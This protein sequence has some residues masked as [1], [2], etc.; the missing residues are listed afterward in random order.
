MAE[1]AN[2][3]K[4]FSS[5]PP[6]FQFY[7]NDWLASQTVSLMTPEQEGA[8][9]RLLAH[10]WSDPTCSLPDDDDRLAVLSRLG[11]KWPAARLA[12]AKQMLFH[13]PRDSGRIYNVRLYR[14]R[15]QLEALSLKRKKAGRKGGN[16]KA[17]RTDDQSW[18]EPSNCQASDKQLG[19]SSSSSPL[20]NRSSDAYGSLF[21]NE[22]T[23]DN[24]AHSGN[25]GK[26]PIAKIAAEIY[27]AYP[28]KAAKQRALKAIQKAIEKTGDPKMLL[29]AVKEFAS[30]EKGRGDPSFIPYPATWFNDGSW[31]DDRKHWNPEEAAMDSKIPDEE[32]FRRLS[33]FSDN[34]PFMP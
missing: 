4:V 27:D 7:A 8:Y 12:I 11:E 30:S 28:K 18:Q 6:A 24:G 10:Q 25:N 16:A 2:P 19:S 34:R 15:E 23:G 22:H 29:E 32:D 26:K 5:K 1:V 21:P 9:I 3:L 33:G 17:L 13:S 20:C 31:E 14:Y